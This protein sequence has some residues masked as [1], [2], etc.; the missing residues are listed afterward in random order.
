LQY[1]LKG[2]RK[3]LTQ[4]FLF[5][6]VLLGSCAHNFCSSLGQLIFMQADV[7]IIGAGAAGLMAARQLLQAGKK[8]IVLEARPQA[9]GRIST[10]VEPAFEQ[11]VE[12][13]AEFVHGRL[14][15]T[16]QLL[17]E[18]GLQTLKAGGD[19]W[20][21]EGGRLKK[22]EDFIADYEL[23]IT[24]LK[25]LEEDVTVAQFLQ[26]H[27][28]SPKHEAMRKTLKSYVEGYYAGDMQK[29]SAFALRDE[30]EG[31]DDEDERIAGG[32]GLL[33]QY[34]QQECKKEGC[35]FYFGMV[36]TQITWQ[37][38]A[39]T[40]TTQKGDL[41]QSAKLL[42]TVSVGVLQK[43]LIQFSPRIDAT[44]AA[45]QQLGFGSVIKILLQLKQPF[46]ETQFALDKLAFLFSE[47]NIPT[48]WTQHPQGSNMLTGWC[49]GPA[50][51]ALQAESS[52]ALLEKAITSLANCFSLS[53]ATIKENI[54]AWK[55]MNWGADAYTQGGYSYL[56]VQSAKAMAAITTPVENTIYFAGEGLVN[57][58]E[59]GTVEAALQ[60]GRQAAQ[61]IVGYR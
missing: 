17:K 8:V 28:A 19:I 55:V 3:V 26:T 25:S 5:P 52:D 49:A 13:G 2:K 14:P 6:F 59:I 45:A 54:S 4:T 32:Y 15:L 47:Q 48:W 60:S 50:A 38:N 34:L 22:E 31:A 21:S 7:I 57:G 61:Q 37:K 46:W 58:L 35:Q 10:F 9:G 43:E 53:A 11:P 27:F 1:I 16:H 51:Q 41:F 40:V 20:R 33:V 36:V 12:G 39:V 29:A 30:L 18:A 42:V 23:L 44:I 24:A 56:T